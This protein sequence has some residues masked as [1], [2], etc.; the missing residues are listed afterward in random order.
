MSYGVGRR[1]GPDLALLQLWHRP[2]ARALIQP[3]A[4]EL[5]YAAPAALKKNKIKQKYTN[6]GEPSLTLCG[7]FFSFFTDE[8]AGVKD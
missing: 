1:C 4:W 2:A 6:I 3:L 8:V 7:F 5:P